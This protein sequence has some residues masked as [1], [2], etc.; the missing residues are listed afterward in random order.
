MKSSATYIPIS[1][2][3]AVLPAVSAGYS[4]V[5]KRVASLEASTFAEGDE[6]RFAFGAWMRELESDLGLGPE[7]VI[8]ILQLKLNT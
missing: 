4:A 7:K 6:R 8:S 2:T 5:C 3:T 1:P